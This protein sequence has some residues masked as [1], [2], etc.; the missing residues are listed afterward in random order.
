VY[1]VISLLL[2]L[3][4]GYL[5]YHKAIHRYETADVQSQ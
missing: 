1:R 4:T 3:L 2:S 5:L